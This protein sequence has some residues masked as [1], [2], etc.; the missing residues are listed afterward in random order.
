M[1]HAA[2]PGLTQQGLILINQLLDEVVLSLSKRLV[3]KK[4]TSP[5]LA[6]ALNLSLK[7]CPLIEESIKSTNRK[8]PSLL[9]VPMRPL[10][11][12]GFNDDSRASLDPS[13]FCH[14]YRLLAHYYSPHSELYQSR[15]ISEFFKTQPFVLNAEVSRYLAA[16]MAQLGLSVIR[17]CADSLLEQQSSMQVATNVMSTHLLVPKLSELLPDCTIATRLQLHDFPHIDPTPD[18]LAAFFPASPTTP[19]LRTS[20]DTITTCSSSRPNSISNSQCQAAGHRR[21]SRS[22][23]LAHIKPPPGALD[24]SDASPQ[25]APLSFSGGFL[26]SRP[27]LEFDWL[28]SSILS[29]T[30]PLPKSRTIDGAEFDTILRD[31]STLRLTLT[32][33]RLATIPDES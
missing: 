6:V 1:R 9:A 18:Q 28:A 26:R 5:Q 33:N 8:F 15:R 12:S 13:L 32:P 4:F 11:S 10:V 2:A 16:I 27:S 25:T 22:L 31:N 30:R 17:E 24:P 14:H 3:S 7:S 19:S 29:L 20:N 21:L 23:S